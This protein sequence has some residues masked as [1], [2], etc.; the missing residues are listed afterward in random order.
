VL[1]RAAAFLLAAFPAYAQTTGPITYKLDP[2]KSWIYVVV[3]NENSAMGMGHDHGVKAMDFTGVV[4]WDA[5]DPSKCQIDITIPVQKLDPD[6]PGLREREKLPADEAVGEWGLGEIKKNFLG[7]SQLDADHH[8]TITYRST[9]CSAVADNKVTVNGDLTIRGKT[10]AV[11]TTMFVTPTPTSFTAGGVFKARATDF[12]FK[13]YSN[14]LG[15]L[16][17]HDEMKFVVDVVGTPAW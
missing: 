17:N 10:K 12:G 16:T 7:G 14:L 3:Y 13:P 9:S 11:T 15:A 4:V 2:Q 6:P 5:L 1:L 8:P